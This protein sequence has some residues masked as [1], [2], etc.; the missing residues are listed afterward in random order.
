MLIT[1]QRGALPPSGAMICWV[2]ALTA[3]V[4]LSCEGADRVTGPEGGLPAVIV[5]QSVVGLAVGD[6]QRLAA[7]DFDGAAGSVTWRSSDSSIA[8]VSPA[9]M[10]VGKAWGTTLVFAT[11]ASRVYGTWVGVEPVDAAVVRTMTVSPVSLDVRNGAKSAT[12]AVRIVSPGV[13]VATATFKL[14]RAAG[15]KSCGMDRS[16]GT[17][18]EGLWSCSASLGADDAG[19]SVASVAFVDSANVRH[20]EFTPFRVVRPIVLITAPD[21]D[22]PALTTANITLDSVSISGST[23]IFAAP[24]TI[25]PRISTWLTD[26]TGVSFVLYTLTPPPGSTAAPQYLA[27][28]C[29]TNASAVTQCVADPRFTAADVGT[30]NIAVTASDVVGNSVSFTSAQLAAAGLRSTIKVAP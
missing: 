10:V 5:G 8:T 17:A 30:W 20:E 24:R 6:S 1:R 23:P 22:P 16:F 2:F 27:V 28:P 11:A 26:A 25:S 4:I 9:G 18:R 29:N 3:C 7:P 19:A 12:V 14:V 21:T 13:G 15:D